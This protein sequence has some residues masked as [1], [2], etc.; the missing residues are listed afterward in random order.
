MQTGMSTKISATG[1]ELRCSTLNVMECWLKVSIFKLLHILNSRGDCEGLGA[2]IINNN[3]NNN[4]ESWHHDSGCQHPPN[5]HDYNTVSLTRTSEIWIS[6][7]WISLTWAY[8]SSKGNSRKKKNI[9]L[10]L[11]SIRRIWELCSK[12]Y[13]L[14]TKGN[15]K[16]ANTACTS[17]C[18]S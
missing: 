12:Q 9:F 14:F 4:N 16:I 6:L 2:C 17:A 8:C 13:R 10:F 5:L 18:F 7:A 3:N 15:L 1:L 11:L